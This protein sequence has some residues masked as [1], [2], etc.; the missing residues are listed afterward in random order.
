MEHL[1]A[2]PKPVVEIH[3]EMEDVLAAVDR[4]LQAVRAAAAPRELT[5]SEL[6]RELA[7]R[8]RSKA[9]S[10][11]ERWMASGDAHRMSD[12]D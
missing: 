11:Y 5:G 10:P 12:F 2:L 3:D 9:T 6:L 7:R 8:G 1:P 4:E